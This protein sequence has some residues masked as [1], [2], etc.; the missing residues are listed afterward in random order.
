LGYRQADCSFD[1]HLW[2]LGPARINAAH[3]MKRMRFRARA[4][5][6]RADLVLTLGIVAGLRCRLELAA[7]DRDQGWSTAQWQLYQPGK[8]APGFDPVESKPRTS[9][10]LTR[11]GFFVRV[12]RCHS[13]E[14]ARLSRRAS[15]DQL[16]VFRVT[17][18]REVAARASARLSCERN[19]GP[20]VDAAGIG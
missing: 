16:R 17:M 20:D 9:E 1:F 5:P 2:G 6:S 18:R 10:I 3:A 4:E 11:Q 14:K 7:I 15:A 19:L 8:T 13:N 12:R